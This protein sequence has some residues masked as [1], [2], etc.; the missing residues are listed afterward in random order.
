MN[1]RHYLSVIA[2]ATTAGCIAR[3][4]ATTQSPTSNEGPESVKPNDVSI[5]FSGETD[6]ELTLSIPDG[7]YECVDLHTL[8]TRK[9]S[10]DGVG[11]LSVT[12][13]LDGE[14]VSGDL[15]T[16]PTYQP[17]DNRLYDPSIVAE[18]GESITIVLSPADFG[19]QSYRVSYGLTA[20]PE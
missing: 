1:R 19:E 3:E 10:D 16:T 14:P 7:E 17:G 15:D 6:Q 2:A 18:G 13:E 20:I 4:A 9:S 8:V 12:F 11:G 5:T